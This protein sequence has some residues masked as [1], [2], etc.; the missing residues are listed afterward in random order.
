MDSGTLFYVTGATLAASAILFSFAAL[1]FERFPG[2]MAP[3]VAIWFAALVGGA[4]TLAV[5]HA[6][7]EQR[8]KAAEVSK[9]NE[10]SERAE[11]Q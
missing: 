6:K 4:T 10:E 5:L 3:L 7:D 2:R 11:A 9:A 8:E 1:R